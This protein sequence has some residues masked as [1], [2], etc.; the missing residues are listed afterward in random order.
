MGMRITLGELIHKLANDHE[1]RPAITM[2]E[3]G[4]TLSYRQ[5]DN[6]INQI[7]H[8]FL[9]LEHASSRYVGIMHENALSYLAMTYALKK[10]DRVEVS[11]NRAF[12]GPALQRMINLTE[13]RVLMTSEAHFDAL[14]EIVD[15]LPHL[16]TLILTSGH[17]RAAT[18]FPRLER[19]DFEEMLSE[20][21]SHIVS[22][23][24]DTDLAAIMFTSGTTG[25]SKGC[26]LSHRYAVRT[27]ENMIEPF[28]LTSE[29]VNY[30]P[31]PLSH[32]GPAY[33]D[34]LPSFMVGGRAVLRDHFSLSNFWHEVTH[35]GVTWFMCLGSVQQLLYSAPPTGLDRKH[36]V[37][38]IW[39]TP[40][41][42]SGED[43]NAR[44]GVHVMPGGGYGSTDAG[45]VVVPQWDHPGGKVLPHFDI[46][47]VDENDDPV[48]PGQKGELV[49]RPK[50][51]GVMADGYFGMPEKTLETRRNLWFHT[52]DIGWI[53]EEGLFYFT[54]RMAERIRVRGE[55]VSGF[56][57]E[58]GALSHPDIEDAAAI[59]VPAAMGE[60]DIRLFV[61][62]K[63]GSG[64]DADAIREHCRRK[65][66]KFM[67]PA[68]V[69]VLD[70]MPRT[71]TG[72]PEKGKLAEMPV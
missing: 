7:A 40:A 35:H 69:T 43:F 14:A 44:F 20:D 8:G 19:L 67:V 10:I 2:A 49:I 22:S 28:R 25:V 71:T 6:F 66:A 18:L 57:V 72:K 52:G 16:R 36:R 62:L 70:E 58:E 59:G 26:M 48:P 21:R 13:C 5:F 38:R 39:S 63:R 64:L 53:D 68:V 12:R 17:A 4:E 42:V 11:I 65:M 31:Y 61:T 50:E 1:D 3:T 27:A 55:M 29:D 30:T 45:W 9:T 60:E 41:P 47:I 32:I 56:E 34:I 37:T 24:K 46:A 51:P 15:E 54:C 23:A 33:Y